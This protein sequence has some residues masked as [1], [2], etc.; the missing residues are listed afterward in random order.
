[1]PYPLVVGEN[2]QEV[3]YRS[4]APSC[5]MQRVESNYPSRARISMAYR[6]FAEINP[7]ILDGAAP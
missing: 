4:R 1:M 5:R 7:V 3:N 6:R 2:W